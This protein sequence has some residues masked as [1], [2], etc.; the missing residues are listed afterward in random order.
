LKFES[1]TVDTDVTNSGSGN[2]VNVLLAGHVK[3][4]SSSTLASVAVVPTENG[5]AGI[6]QA[7][8]ESNIEICP[9]YALLAS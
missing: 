2:V 7:C 6:A 5:A 9:F 8:F 1:I 4:Q 3:V